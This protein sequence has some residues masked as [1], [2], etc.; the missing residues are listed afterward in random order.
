MKNKKGNIREVKT[1]GVEFKSHGNTFIRNFKHSM[2]H[3]PDLGDYG[4]T[5]LE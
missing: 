5:M 1:F 3:A 4:Q 2:E